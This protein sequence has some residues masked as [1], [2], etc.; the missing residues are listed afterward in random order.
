MLRTAVGWR[1]WDNGTS[2]SLRNTKFRITRQG[3]QPS[4]RSAKKSCFRSIAMKACC[5]VA[6]ELSPTTLASHS[7]E[8]GAK[9]HRTGCLVDGSQR[10]L[11]LR[12]K[13]NNLLGLMPKPR[14]VVAVDRFGRD[15]V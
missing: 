12:K 8:I 11:F 14:F 15:L 1:G 7:I 2:S 6:H 4:T 9:L 13:A 3:L 10:C 5:R